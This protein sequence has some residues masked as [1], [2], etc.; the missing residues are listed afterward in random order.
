[1]RPSL[2]SSKTPAPAFV[3]GIGIDGDQTSV[4]VCAAPGGPEGAMLRFDREATLA[5][6]P[7]VVR[8]AEELIAYEARGARISWTEA[9]GGGDALHEVIVVPPQV[10]PFHDVRLEACLAGTRWGNVE[11][12]EASGYRLGHMFDRDRCV[13]GVATAEALA[14]SGWAAPEARRVTSA[15]VGLLELLRAVEPRS[16]EPGGRP[17]MG[18]LCESTALAACVVENG[19]VRLLH[20][21]SLLGYFRELD[22]TA[23]SSAVE[24]PDESCEPEYEFGAAYTIPTGAGIRGVARESDLAAADV[25]SGAYQ[26]SLMR[27]IQELLALYREQYGATAPFPQ[28]VLVTGDATTRHAV[29]AYLARYLGAQFEVDELDAALVVRIDDPELAR[30]FASMQSVYGGALAA[31]AAGMRDGV[32]TFDLGPAPEAAH[33]RRPAGR[34]RSASVALSP[35]ALAA[36]AVTVLVALVGGGIRLG[37]IARERSRLEAQLHVETDRQAQLRALTEERKQSEARLAHTRELLAALDGLRGRQMLPPGLLASVQASLPEATSLDE[38]SFANGVV[39]IAGSSR[40]KETATELALALER[41]R[42]TFADVV[43]Q[44]DTK[45]VKTRDEATDEERLE[46]AYTFTITARYVE[47]AA[48]PAGPAAGLARK[49]Q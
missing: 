28:T 38:I 21:T 15:A 13:V 33:T 34:T 22:S 48:A 41:R 19:E 42:E 20:Q 5:E 46:I 35:S 4:V 10:R 11:A 25:E 9:L 8:E 32:L 26:A 31:L 44:T 3:G 23:R 14:R 6:L 7:H 47:G 37:L 36:F 30:R 18:L 2:R 27:V 39:R 12:I 43:P 29:R 45:V 49:E 17:V 1:V 16:F 24:E 40:E